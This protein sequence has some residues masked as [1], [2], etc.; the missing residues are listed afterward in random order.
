[1]G[2]VLNYG[3]EEWPERKNGLLGACASGNWVMV[4][5]WVRLGAV[6]TLKM[7][8]AASTVL[9]KYNEDLRML[10]PDSDS[11]DADTNFDFIDT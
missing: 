4:Q 11:D 7:H 10:E 8:A 2:D 5:K 6:V 3:W 9:E 1:M